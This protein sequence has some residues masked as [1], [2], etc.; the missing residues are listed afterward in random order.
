MKFL[1]LNTDFR[2]FL[3]WL[4]AQHPGL[5][6]KSYEE[7]ERAISNSQFGIAGFYSSNLQKLGHE[8]WDIHVN[9]EFIQRAWAKEHGMRVEGQMPIAEEWKGILQRLRRIAARTPLRHLRPTFSPIL[10]RMGILEPS[11]YAF[12]AE[13]I[14]YY[15]PDIVLNQVMGNISSQFLREMKSNA[16]LL[17]GQIACPLPQEEDF[18]C[19]DIVI[20]SLPNL[21]NYFRDLGIPAELNRLAFE[22]KVLETIKDKDRKTISASFVGGLSRV[23]ETR[24]RWLEYICDRTNLDIWGPSV[25]SLPRNSSIRNHYKGKA[26]GKDMYQILHRSKITLNHHID[27]AGSYANNLRLFEA[28][29]VGTFLITDSKVNLDEMFEPGREMIT[30]RSPEECA[31]LIKYYLEHDEERERIARAG[32]KRTLRDHTYYH[33]MQELVDILQKHI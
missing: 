32:Q 33:R 18:T 5:E 2:D 17:V 14:S 22:P 23:H 16:R 24:N 9:N 8:A 11:L 27:V 25:D 15:K 30:Y 1:I 28:T 19:Y 12:L 20:S 6:E 3:S 13:Q 26:W 29:G 21:V 10:R 31:K 7:Q 4:Y